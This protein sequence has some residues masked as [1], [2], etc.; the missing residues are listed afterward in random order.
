MLENTAAP[1]TQVVQLRVKV[2]RTRERAL[3]REFGLDEADLSEAEVERRRDELK[4]LV[5]AGKPRGFLTHQEIN[6]HLPEKLVATETV[7]SIVAMLSDMGIVVYEH[8]PDA[9]VLFMSGELQSATS[10]EAE[11]AAE[12]AVTTVDPCELRSSASTT[13][14][15]S[16]VG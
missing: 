9:A 2:S 12:A 13:P 7:D 11:E 14:R 6:D 4:K 5:V 15:P 3:A 8:A 16:W 10:E 1:S